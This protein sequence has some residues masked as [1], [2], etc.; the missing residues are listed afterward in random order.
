MIEAIKSEES[1]Q[2]FLTDECQENRCA[3]EIDETIEKEDIAI[4]KIDDY[5]NSLKLSKTPPSIDHLI[6]VSREEG[7]FNLFLVE[8]KDIK[9]PRYFKV[10]NIKKKFRTTIDDFMSI[11][12]KVI[13]LN[14]VYKINKIR[15]YF[16]TD[17]YDWTNKDIPKEKLEKVRKGTKLDLVMQVKPFRFRGKLY[18]IKHELPNPLITNK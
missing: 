17:P 12:Y 3:A 8:L 10:D 2:P 11:K 18:Q 14:E 1:L 13:F 4:I 15:L 9:S 7:D 16:V 6:T 5:Y